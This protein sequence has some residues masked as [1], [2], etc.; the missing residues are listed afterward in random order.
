ME[1]HENLRKD[2]HA[3]LADIPRKLNTV[4]RLTEIHIKSP[5][6]HSCTDSVFLSVFIVLERIIDKLS[7]SFTGKKLVSLA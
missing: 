7:K 1:K 5:E 3:A 2:I 6:L 4:H